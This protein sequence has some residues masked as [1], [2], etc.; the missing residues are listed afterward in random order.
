MNMKSRVSYWFVASAILNGLFTFLLSP[1]IADSSFG[2]LYNANGFPDR[3]AFLARSLVNGDGL[4]FFPDTAETIIRT[5]GYPIILAQLFHYFGE[6]LLA[7]KI[8]NYVLLLPT[9]WMSARIAGLV[10]PKIPEA[11]YLTPMIVLLYPGIIVAETRGGVEILLTFALTLFIFVLIY[12]IRKN[13]WQLYLLSGLVLGFASLVKSTPLLFPGVFLFYLVW[14]G[15]KS[16]S[17]KA[18]LVPF[19]CI[20]LG[21]LV[22]L[23]PWIYRNSVLVGRPIPTM[24]VLGVAITQGQYI[25]ENISLHNGTSELITQAT[26]DIAKL[27]EGQG[28]PFKG[29]D[30][31][32]GPFFL[33]SKDELEFADYLKKEAFNKYRTSPGLFVKCSTLNLFD[34]WFAGRT[35]MATL[36]NVLVQLPLI[37]FSGI[38]LVRIWRSGDIIG[39]LPI[40]LFIGYYMLVHLPIMALGRHSIPL[41][42]LMSVFAAVGVVS[43]YKGIRVHKR[44][45]S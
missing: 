29:I 30:P 24:T 7:A 11:Q 3:Y 10:L 26:D 45:R 41:V 42:P 34:F 35:H 8:L 12:A 28:R 1:F 23:T 17:Y 6:S 20:I 18:V 19:V 38:G 13:Q 43:I 22:I 14:G 5:P 39:V 37:V 33:S 27:A 16:D 40:V 2:L 36:L 15:W 25:C 4:R 31:C 9:A 32:C 44:E 21:V